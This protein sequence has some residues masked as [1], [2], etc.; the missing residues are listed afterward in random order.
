[1][2][3]FDDRTTVGAETLTGTLRSILSSALTIAALSA[4]TSAAATASAHA[5]TQVVDQSTFNA[6]TTNRTTSYFDSY[7]V[8]G[9][10]FMGYPSVTA[11]TGTFT[12]TDGGSAQDININGPSYAAS[13]GHDFL[14]NTYEGDTFTGVFEL[15]INLSS[16]VTAF[17]LDYG[18]SASGQNVSFSLS[19]GATAST[20][21]TQSFFDGLEFIG[22]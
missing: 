2:K 15:T 17:G 12:G 5:G 18:T 6:D 21:T 14:T 11:G 16:P 4:I 8:T 10:N 9:S 1:M 22:F 19:N 7:G 3:A 20:T 13:G